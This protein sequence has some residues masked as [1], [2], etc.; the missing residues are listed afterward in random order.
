M[1]EQI[2]QIIKSQKVILQAFLMAAIKWEL[3]DGVLYIYFDEEKGSFHK[4]RCQETDNL[5]MI[6]EAAQQAL[7]GPVTVVCS[8]IPGQT[9]DPIQKAIDLFG[10]EIVKIV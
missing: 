10:E 3:H 9:Q 6:R 5:E 4:E 1:Q 2:L 7:G 8:Y